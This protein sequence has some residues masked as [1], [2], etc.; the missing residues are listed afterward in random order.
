MLHRPTV[1]TNDTS[2]W[3]RMKGDTKFQSETGKRKEN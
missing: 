2:S 1:K 3:Y